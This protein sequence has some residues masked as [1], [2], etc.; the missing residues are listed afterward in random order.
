MFILVGV[1]SVFC[2]SYLLPFELVCCGLH[3]YS[4]WQIRMSLL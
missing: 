2:C 4:F 1:K 3:T